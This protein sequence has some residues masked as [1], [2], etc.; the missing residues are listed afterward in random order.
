[1]NM[2]R[3]PTSACEPTVSIEYLERCGWSNAELI[4]EQIQEEAARVWLLGDEDEAAA[5]WQGALDIAEE[6]FTSRDPRRVTS[7]VNA[8][9][10]Y[11]PG[12]EGSAVSLDAP[13]E[14][15]D[16]EPWVTNLKPIV[17]AR[18]S[19]FHLRLR[20]K[21]RGA[22]DRA[23]HEVYRSLFQQGL[24]QLRGGDDETR[25]RQRVTRWYEQ[26]PSGFNDYRK[27]LAAVLL[28]RDPA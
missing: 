7:R 16:S 3:K 23:D 1:M 21:H 25:F 24:N 19:M 13:R 27:L 6:H 22:Y 28:L 4:W 10:G 12:A 14:W 15:V 20:T 26:K 2:S 18:S 17:R 8:A 5:L 11:R 9:P